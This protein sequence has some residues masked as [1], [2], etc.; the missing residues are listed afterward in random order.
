MKRRLMQ[1]VLAAAIAVATLSVAA[2]ASARPAPGVQNFGSHVSHCARD[3][4]FDRAHN[5]G[6]HQGAAGWTGSE[7]EH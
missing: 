3:M 7:C 4:G 6:M 1:G 5:P 2:P